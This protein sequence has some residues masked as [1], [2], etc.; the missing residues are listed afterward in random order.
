MSAYYHDQCKVKPCAS[1]LSRDEL[2]MFEEYQQD[3]EGNC[4]S[5]CKS[6]K[7]LKT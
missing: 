7:F 3:Y 5:S 6:S 4:I 2:S 1:I